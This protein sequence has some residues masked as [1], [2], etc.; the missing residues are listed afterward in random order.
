MSVL[1]DTGIIVGFRN[2]RDDRHGRAVE[3]VDA[4]RRGVH[5]DAFTSDYVFGECI[6]LALARTGRAEV[7]RAVG[8]LILPLE[9]SQ[10][11]IRL[12]HVSPEEFHRAW[13][14]VRKHADAR[15]SF[16]DWTLVEMVRSRG[17]DGVASF[18]AGLDAWVARIA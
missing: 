5:G 9:S 6:G 17:I 10:R 14:L 13:A 4:I 7:V 2:P 15:L 1:V 18:D 12:L 3:L 16:T 8:E 11:W